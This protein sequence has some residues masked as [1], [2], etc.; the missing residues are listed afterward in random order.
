MKITKIEQQKK[1]QNRY[2][3]YID[4]AFFICVDQEILIQ[5]SLHKDQ[6][7]TKELL[8]QIKTSENNHK[9][10][11]ASLNYLSYGLR[12]IKEMRDYLNK[13]KDK[14]EKAGPSDEVIEATIDRLI[15]QGYL[16]DL[17]YAK[18]YVRTHSSLK[19]KG[20]QVIQNELKMKKGIN[21]LDILD[22]LEE[23]ALEDQIENIHSLSEKYIRTNKSH[24]PKMLRNKLY[25][26]LLTKGF[27][28]DLVN[29]HMSELTFEESQ[30]QQAELLDK[31]AAKYLRKHQRRFSGYD[32]K[33]KITQSL[34]SRGYDYEYIKNWLED[35]EDI[36]DQQ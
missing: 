8:E 35:H 22:A 30:E 5:F 24:P 7:V 17:E 15:R 28:K 23:Y 33:Q 21:E 29:Q 1:Q 10:Y 36:L 18:S 25:T 4:E 32:L 20:P 14:E 34:L 27:D 31:E 11:A 9:I 3:L 12:S 19:A 2:S 26:H 16:N 13:Q 6:V